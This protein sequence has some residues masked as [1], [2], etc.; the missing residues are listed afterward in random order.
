MISINKGWG[1][2]SEPRVKHVLVKFWFYA[3][4]DSINRGG[5]GSVEQ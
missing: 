1:S 5:V 2:V 4:I 3:F